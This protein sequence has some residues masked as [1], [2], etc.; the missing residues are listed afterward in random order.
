MPYVPQPYSA[1]LDTLIAALGSSQIVLTTGTYANPVWITSL[2]WAKLTGVPTTFAPSAHTHGNITNVGAIGSTSGLPIVTGASGVLQAGSFGTTAGSVC[3][4]N[5]SRLSDA[6]TPTAHTHGNI[7]NVGAIGNTANLPLITGASGV[8]QV[9]SFGTTA[10]TFCQGNDSRLSDART[11]I[12]HNQAAET[13]TSGTLDNARLSAQVV[14]R[15]QPNTFSEDQRIQKGSSFTRF[16]VANANQH[17]G[18]EAST[19][20]GSFNLFAWHGSDNVYFDR[21]GT[22]G[23]CTLEFRNNGTVGMRLNGNNMIDMP[24][25]L[26]AQGT[27]TLNNSLFDSDGPHPRWFSNIHNIILQTNTGRIEFR[28]DSGT[29]RVL[30]NSSGLVV[31]G[32]VRAGVF[33]VATLPSAS[34]NASYFATVTDSSVTTNGSPVSGGGSNRVMVFSNGTT[35]DVVVA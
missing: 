20:Q 19:P 15:D 30:I 12:A 13:I 8:I 32:G 16:W 25:G 17:T 14:R 24:F 21:A 28:T 27:I 22:S 26:N 2:N 33:T 6:R 34:A 7:T 35:W 31:N 9:G 3:Q 18:L 5:D 4:G 29:E 11:P 10:N 23:G 1:A